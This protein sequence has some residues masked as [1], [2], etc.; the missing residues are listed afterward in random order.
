MNCG[1]SD[2]AAHRIR[3]FLGAVWVADTLED[4][5]SPGWRKV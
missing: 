4:N 5:T 2:D 1:L 3:E